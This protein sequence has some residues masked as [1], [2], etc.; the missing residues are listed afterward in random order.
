[1]LLDI[2]NLSKTYANGVRALDD[3]SLRLGP[4]MFGLLGPNGAG[5]TTLM[6]ILATLLR[7]D[8]GSVSLDGVDLLREPQAV[9]RQ[10]GYLPQEFGVYPHTS[11][12]EMLDYLA[13]LKGISDAKAR[14]GEVA[15][16]LELVNL[17][18]V[19]RRAVDSFSGGMRRRFGV[20]QALLGD[21][22]LVI[23]DEPTAGLD[24]AE[25]HRFHHLLTEI[26]SRT[27]VLLSTHIVEDVAHLCPE[28]GILDGGR[29]VVCGKPAALLA[30]AAGRLWIKTVAKGEVPA[31]RE[32]H[33]VLSTRL[34]LGTVA[35]IVRSDTPPGDGFEPKTP[36]LEDV[37]FTHVRHAAEA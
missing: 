32:K 8:A 17:A 4:G 28:M 22:R 9:R 19:R 10:L 18:D 2:Q 36:D 11:A 21:P 29:L 35:L 6:N 30:E 14:C 13:Q 34:H 27:I 12:E 37:Y 33:A 23:V 31:H 25:R 5:K 1:M 3:V 26:S 7:P 15:R 24:P 16:L 20:A